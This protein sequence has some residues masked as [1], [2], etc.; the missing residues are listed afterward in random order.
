[1]RAIVREKDDLKI[2]RHFSAGSH[3][4][5]CESPRSG[6][7][8]SQARVQP[9]VSWTSLQLSSY[10]PALKGWA[11]FNRRLRRLR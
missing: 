7:L 6:R 11:I 4:R 5:A 8:R 3:Q 9:S 10:F 2:A 1:M